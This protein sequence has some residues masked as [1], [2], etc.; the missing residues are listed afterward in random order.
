[1]SMT[2]KQ[3]FN[4]IVALAAAVLSAMAFPAAAKDVAGSKD[5]SLIGRYQG[6]EILFYKQSDFDGQRL[7][8][9]AMD[10]KQSDVLSAANSQAVEGKVFRI[11]YQ[12]PKDR[13]SLEIF[14]NYEA[15]LKSKGFEPVFACANEQCTSGDTGFYRF[16]AAIDDVSQNFRYQKSVRYVLAKLTRPQGDVFAAILVG[17]AVDPVVRV[18]VV[19]MKPIETDKIAFVDASAME[20]SIAAL[21]HVTLYGVLFD[22]DKAEIKPESKPTLDEIAKFMKANPTINLIVAGHTDNQGA[23][24]YNVDLSRRRAASVVQALVGARG[25]APS[26]LVSFGAGMAAPV[27]PNDTEAGRAKNRRVELVKR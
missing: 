10:F 1:M 18:T 12:A 26:R 27:A 2:F 22:T 4:V 17:E 24:D 19:E 7:L 13:S 16:G 23:F 11:R 21:G 6:S 20:K 14:R 15:S 9:R 3:R 25:V 8:D 5:H